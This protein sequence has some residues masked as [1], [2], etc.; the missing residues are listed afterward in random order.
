LENIIAIV[1]EV[2]EDLRGDLLVRMCCWWIEAL[3]INVWSSAGVRSAIERR[4]RGED[5]AERQRRAGVRIRRG[6]ILGGI[7]VREE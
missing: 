2:R 3:L 5:R 4:C 6:A 7:E 1:W